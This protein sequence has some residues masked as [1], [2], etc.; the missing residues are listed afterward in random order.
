MEKLSHDLIEKI[1]N[2]LNLDDI[3][4]F[5]ITNSEYYFALDNIFYINLAN[6]LYS[7]EFWNKAYL[8]PIIKSKPLKKM[9]LEL[10]RI[11]NF[12]KILDSLNNK[13]WTKKDFYN[14]WI[15]D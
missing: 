15:L 4:S 13:R 8:R 10:I 6:K 2:Y 5:S 12:Q 7:I 3:L 14:Y 11:E 9:K 1:A